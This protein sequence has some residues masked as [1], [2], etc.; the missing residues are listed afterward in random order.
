VRSGNRI[1]SGT[2]Y[3]EGYGSERVV[4]PLTMM[5]MMMMM[6]IVYSAASNFLKLPALDVVMMSPW[7]DE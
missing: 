2:I 6:T 3:K 7:K 4:L 5:M 1:K